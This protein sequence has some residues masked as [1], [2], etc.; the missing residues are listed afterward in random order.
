VGFFG[1]EKLGQF[2][3][4]NIAN[5]S[6]R[7]AS[8]DRSL[9]VLTFLGLFAKIVRPATEEMPDFRGNSRFGMHP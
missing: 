7:R 2:S 4:A 6:W 9:L 8:K 5:S 3:F 1:A